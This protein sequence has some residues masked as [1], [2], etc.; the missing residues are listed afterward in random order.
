M[1]GTLKQHLKARPNLKLRLIKKW[2]KQIVEGL[3]YLHEKEIIHRDLK[4]DNIFINVQQSK[5]KIGDL[6]MATTTSSFKFAVS[7]IGTPEFMAPE[8]FDENY[9]NSVDIYA[10]GMCVLEM[11]TGEFPYAECTTPIQIIRKVMDGK[12]PEAVENITD[13]KLKEFIKMCINHSAEARPT[14]KELMTSTFLNEVDEE[15]DNIMLTLKGEEGEN[16]GKGSHE[17]DGVTV[18][19]ESV[20]EEKNYKQL[21]LAIY[22]KIN[23]EYKKIQTEYKTG[24]D[25]AIQIANDMTATFSL[26]TE[27]R[28]SI[29]VAIEKIVDAKEVKEEETDDS[30]SDEEEEY[31]VEE[32]E[33]DYEHQLTSTSTASTTSIQPP[34][35]EQQE[36]PTTIETPNE[37]E[38]EEKKQKDPFLVTKNKEE[39]EEKKTNPFEKPK[40]TTMTELE[41]MVTTQATNTPK[42]QHFNLDEFMN[43][44][45]GEHID[46]YNNE[47]ANLEKKTTERLAMVDLEMEKLKQKRAL[48]CHRYESRKRQIKEKYKKTPSPQNHSHNPFAVTEEVQNMMMDVLQRPALPTKTPLL[49]QP[50]TLVGQPMQTLKTFRHHTLTVE[51]PAAKEVS[52]VTKTV[53]ATLPTLKTNVAMNST[54]THTKKPIFNVNAHMM[55]TT[56]ATTATTSAATTALAQTTVAAAAAASSTTSTTA[57]SPTL[58]SHS[59]LSTPTITPIQQHHQITTPPLMTSPTNLTGTYQSLTPTVQST[60]AASSPNNTTAV[61]N[62]NHIMRSQSLHTIPPHLH[63]RSTSPPIPPSSTSSTSQQQQPAP[64]TN[65]VAF[66]T[67]LFPPTVTPPRSS[68]DDQFTKKQVILNCF[69]NN[70]VSSSMTNGQATMNVDQLLRHNLDLLTKKDK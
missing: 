42:I 6:G 17:S 65:L 45:D 69:N 44:H 32:E 3:L 34:L 56:T 58:S 29:K 20:K 21:F 14:A 36:T 48:I 39:E 18:V 22:I 12:L 61:M 33:E 26:S 67:S 59:T 41:N 9:G 68:K 23:G 51:L 25:T 11:A 13:T 60:S 66:P 52:I 30:S 10:F 43:D 28:D 5:I 24:D 2:S 70:T 64:T 31:D 55:N 15:H 50:P 40:E 46:A 1:T 7:V 57:T 8:M 37:L 53:S 19:V 27:E 49:H 4:C 38:E 62:S 54:M 63:H 35:I 16:P 47:I